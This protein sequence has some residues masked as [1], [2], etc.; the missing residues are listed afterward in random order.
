MTMPPHLAPPYPFVVPTLKSYNEPTIFL[1]NAFA[2]K[3]LQEHRQY[4]Q[5]YLQTIHDIHYRRV[6]YIT[7]DGQIIEM[8]IN[9]FIRNKAYVTDTQ[10]ITVRIKDREYMLRLGWI[11]VDY[12]YENESMEVE[13]WHKNIRYLT[14][15]LLVLIRLGERLDKTLFKIKL[16]DRFIGDDEPIGDTRVMSPSEIKQEWTYHVRQAPLPQLPGIFKKR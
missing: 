16:V 7:N 14:F 13:I 10:R 5:Q 2:S 8:D 9:N 11:I 12:K 15:A 6:F 4:I 3:P 1:K